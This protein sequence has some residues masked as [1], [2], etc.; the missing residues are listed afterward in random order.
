[1]MMGEEQSGYKIKEEG[2]SDSISISR[3]PSYSSRASVFDHDLMLGDKSP[4]QPSRSNS[5]RASGGSQWSGL[6]WKSGD[7]RSLGAFP[8]GLEEKAHIRRLV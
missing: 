2:Q 3:P 8:E 4:T 6:T 1:M 5:A 7:Y